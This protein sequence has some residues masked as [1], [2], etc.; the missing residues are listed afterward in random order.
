MPERDESPPPPSMIDKRAAIG[1]RVARWR[2]SRTREKSARRKGPFS[3]AD[4]EQELDEAATADGIVDIFFAFVSQ[5]FEYPARFSRA[6]RHRRGARRLGSGR[7]AQQG[8]RHRHSAGSAWLVLACARPRRR[9]S[10][11]G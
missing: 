3:R 2:A 5:F 10:S 8:P 4:A 7:E 6:W 1:S 9:S 11:R